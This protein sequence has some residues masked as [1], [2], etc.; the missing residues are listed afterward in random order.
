MIERVRVENKIGHLFVVNISFGERK[1]NEKSLLCNELYT[2]LFVKEN[3][4][5]PGERSVFQL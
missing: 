5:Y 3:I 2:P 4:L 1:A